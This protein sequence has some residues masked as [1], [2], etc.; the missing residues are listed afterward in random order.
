MVGITLS[1]EQ[2]KSAPPEVRRWLEHE[3]AVALGLQAPAPVEAQRASARLVALTVEEAGKVLALIDRRLAEVNVF[4]ELG[5]Q[6]SSVGAEGLEAFRLVDILRHAR[7]QTLDQLAACLDVINEAV[8]QVYADPEATLY[9]LDRRG[10]CLVAE[11]TQRSILSVWQQ[12][13]TERGVSGSGVWPPERVSPLPLDTSA[14][15]DGR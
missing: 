7:L 11:Q 1:P 3:I 13:V 12:A 10:Y 6:G 14:S 4:F 9:L 15:S 8:R 2:I 5:R